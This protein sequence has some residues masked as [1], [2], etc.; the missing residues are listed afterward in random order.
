MSIQL[1][2]VMGPSG[3]GKDSLINWLREQVRRLPAPPAL[4]FARRTITRPQ[5]NSNEDHEA[6]TLDTFTQLQKAGAFALDWEAHGLHYGVRTEEILGRNGWVMVNGSRAYAERARGMFEGMTVLHV[7]A[8]EAVLRARLNE[9]QRE[10]STEVEARIQRSQSAGVA[11]VP[12]D[13]H[14]VNSGTLQASAR[15]LCAVL[16][17]HTGLRLTDSD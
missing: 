2:Y 16:Q 6:V 11:L 12:G 7:T 1:I 5:D 4:H 10:T 9:R 15:E 3:V 14:I 8:P 13:L 17:T